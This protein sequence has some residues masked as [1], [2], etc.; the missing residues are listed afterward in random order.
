MEFTQAFDY[1]KHA[2]HAGAKI[3]R[4]GWNG[5]GMSELAV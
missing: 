4:T 3:T 1:L 2:P 5:A